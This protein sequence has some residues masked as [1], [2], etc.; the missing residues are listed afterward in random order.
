MFSLNVKQKEAVAALFTE[1]FN[2]ENVIEIN[3]VKTLN[4]KLLYYG[5]SSNAI[6]GAKCMVL[7][8]AV[9]IINNINDDKIKVGL[10]NDL[11]M[12]ARCDG[13]C[14]PEEAVLLQALKMALIPPEGKTSVDALI[15]SMRRNKLNFDGRKATYIH[16]DK[17]I[18]AEDEQKIIDMYADKI[19][20]HLD[21]LVLLFYCF[22]YDFVYIPKLREDFGCNPELMEE[23]KNFSF[24]FSNLPKDCIEN[25]ITTF[26]IKGDPRRFTTAKFAKILFSGRENDISSDH[27]APAFLIKISDSYVIDENYLHNG[28]KETK[29][30]KMYNFLYLPI[31]ANGISGIIDTAKDFFQ[32]YIDMVDKSSYIVCPESSKR[33][34]HFDLYQSLIAKIA[35]EGIIKTSPSMVLDISKKYR[36]SLLFEGANDGKDIRIP[37]STYIV[38]YIFSVWCS[39]NASVLEGMTPNELRG[40]AKLIWGHIVLKLG[41]RGADDYQ[42]FKKE[43]SRNC[44][45]I[46]QSLKRNKLQQ[47]VT[48]INDYIPIKIKTRED[49]P[50]YYRISTHN[51]KI[52]DED[53]VK[54]S[55]FEAPIILSINKCFDDNAKIHNKL[56]FQKK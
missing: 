11:E 54:K 51:I 38:D 16:P 45:N 6:K 44:Y 49:G 21:E 27:D 7:E 10:I 26:G 3:K 9:S 48:D 18:V 56:D 12:I 8:E 1:L 30:S 50:I 14:S 41:N 42:S 24:F 55:L 33:I 23:L 20:K 4:Q 28:K 52:I 35:K 31:V 2:A 43:F 36:E 25:A 37:I 5:I 13:Y 39:E 40:I 29:H 32:K 47:Y 46:G 53:N 17:N 19:M 15:F 22:D 34:R